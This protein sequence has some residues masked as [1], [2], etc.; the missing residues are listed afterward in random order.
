MYI[1]TLI[2]IVI[3]KSNDVKKGRHGFKRK[4]IYF[5]SNYVQEDDEYNRQSFLATKLASLQRPPPGSK[6][7]V[8]S[9][10]GDQI[11]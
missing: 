6:A 1:H 5:I 10:N 11:T 4:I 9:S 7:T 2:I 3:D 8:S